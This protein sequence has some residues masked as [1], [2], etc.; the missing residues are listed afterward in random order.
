[1]VRRDVNLESSIWRRS[2][3]APKLIQRVVHT[4]NSYLCIGNWITGRIANR[5][6]QLDKPMERY[7]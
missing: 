2:G 7:D 4:A 5:P 3:S 1:M 6:A